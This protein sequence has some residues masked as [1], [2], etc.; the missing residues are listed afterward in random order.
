MSRGFCVSSARCLKSIT[1]SSEDATLQRPTQI[2][3]ALLRSSHLRELLTEIHRPEDHV[4]VMPT[5]AA[6]QP[7]EERRQ[8]LA[9]GLGQ[10]V[11][12][13]LLQLQVKG[14]AVDEGRRV[15]THSP[16]GVLKPTAPSMTQK[17]THWAGL[18]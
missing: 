12:M 11:Q 13:I 5:E 15:S 14:D 6:V 2:K 3:A 10:L 7:W 9:Q 8:T 4:R 1:E 16:H 17:L 18:V